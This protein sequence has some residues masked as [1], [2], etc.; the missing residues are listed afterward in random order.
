VSVDSNSDTIFY[1]EH[2]MSITPLYGKK[3]Q[4]VVFFADEDR[5]ITL[6]GKSLAWISGEHVYNYAGDHIGWWVDGN[7]MGPDGGLMAWQTRTPYL[8]VT[9]PYPS[10]PPDSPVPSTE[11]IRPTPSIPPFKPTDKIGWSAFTF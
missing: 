3:G 9:L 4:A 6:K 5:I 2:I 7:L 8:G 11:P 1:Q 10:E